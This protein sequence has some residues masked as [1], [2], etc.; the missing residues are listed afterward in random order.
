[1]LTTPM[2]LLQALAQ[3]RSRESGAPRFVSGVQLASDFGVSRTAIWKA[4]RR[5]RQLGTQIDAVPNRGYRLALPASPLDA[6]GVIALLPAPVRSRLRRG[7]CVEAIES[8]NS[9]LL[10]RA[11]PRPGEFDFLTAEHQSAGRGRRGR[12]WLA[13]PGGAVCLSWS[14]SF[15]ALPSEMGALSLAVGVAALRALAQLGLRDVKLKWPNDLVTEGGKLGGILIEMR[16]ESAGPTQVVV[17]IGLNVALPRALRSQLL[18]Q[19]QAAADLAQHMAVPP[20]RNHLVAA[21]LEQG[22]NAM[23][24]FAQEGLAPFLPEYNAA[25]ALRGRAVTLQG[26]HVAFSAG[27]ARGCDSHGALLVEHDSRIHRIIAGEVSVRPE[28]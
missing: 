4:V 10:S 24:Q 20:Q 14:W 13:P 27:M 23:Q 25:D 17:G 5:L 2:Q 7:E 1:M 19:G 28:P 22:I 16:A 6:S 18:S 9:V 26:A 12:A 15:E 3:E 21:L 11:A 8:T